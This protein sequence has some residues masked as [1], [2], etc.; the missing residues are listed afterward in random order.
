MAR[1]GSIL[2]KY[3]VGVVFSQFLFFKEPGIVYTVGITTCWRCWL[4][5]GDAFFSVTICCPLLVVL[6][7]SLC[8]KKYVLV[9]FGVCDLPSQSSSCSTVS[10]PVFFWGAWTPQTIIA[11]LSKTKAIPG[12][13]CC[14]KN[15][16]GICSARGW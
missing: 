1:I 11:G 3:R 2:L 8:K 6:H 13:F 7:S 15:G 4:D 16:P 5:G 9:Y 14:L 12:E 10:F